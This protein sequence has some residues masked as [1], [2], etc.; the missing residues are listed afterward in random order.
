M[1]EIEFK[2]KSSEFRIN[3]CFPSEVISEGVKHKELENAEVSVSIVSG[4]DIKEV[5]SI[6]SMLI[7]F[8]CKNLEMLKGKAYRIFH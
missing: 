7:Y 1:K 4:S 3:T 5:S 6:Q 8:I 2:F